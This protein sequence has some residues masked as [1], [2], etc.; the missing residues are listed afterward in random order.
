MMVAAQPPCT[1]PSGL[2]W[3]SLGTPAKHRPA[4]VDLGQAEIDRARRSAGPDIRRRSAAAAAPA[5]YGAPVPRAGSHPGRV[6]RH[7]PGK[8]RLRSCG[9]FSWRGARRLLAQGGEERSPR[10]RARRGRAARRRGAQGRSRSAGTP[11]RVA[12]RSAR[13]PGPAG[14]NAGSASILSR[15]GS[16]GLARYGAA[17]FRRDIDKVVARA[18]SPRIAPRSRPKPSSS[19]TS[20]S[21]R[22]TS[23][24]ASSGLVEMADQQRQRLVEAGMGIALRQ[25]AQMRRDRLQAENGG[26]AVEQARGI[27]FQRLPTWKVPRC[28]SSRARQTRSTRLPACSTGCCLRERPPRTRPRWRPCAARH[29]LKDERWSRRGGG[30]RG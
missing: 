4:L 10:I 25:Q 30:C 28:S 3:R 29:H 22:T 16:A 18:R 5:R 21:K 1:P 13:R 9:V 2:R 14:R 20:S 15:H 11:D 23:S 26:G 12:A 24:P 6:A 8:V 7:G 17:G 27:Q 19:S